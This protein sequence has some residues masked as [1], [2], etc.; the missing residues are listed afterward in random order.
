MKCYHT[1][2]LLHKSKLNMFADWLVENG[3]TVVEP[4]GA[5]EVLRAVKEN[6]PVII[7]TREN[8]KEHYTV[9]GKDY[10]L[11]KQ[12]IKEIKNGR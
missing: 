4:K 2:N 8:A 10:A 5:Y 6:A 7:Y 3:Y 9:Q 1:R 12:F 11:V